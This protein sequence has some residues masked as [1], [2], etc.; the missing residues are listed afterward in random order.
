MVINVQ[1][2]RVYGSVGSYSVIRVAGYIPVTITMAF[3][4]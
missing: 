1:E 3:H 2:I 4:G